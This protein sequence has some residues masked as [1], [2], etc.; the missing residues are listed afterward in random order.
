MPGKRIGDRKHGP[1]EDRARQPSEDRGRLRRRSSD[2]NAEGLS[3][4]DAA[5]LKAWGKS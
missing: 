4:A 3:A 1:Q 5:R 2:P